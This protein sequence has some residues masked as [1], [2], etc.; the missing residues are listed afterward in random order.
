MYFESQELKVRLC[1]LVKV[2]MYE[3]LCNKKDP[4]LN[5]GYSSM[6]N[7]E[8]GEGAFTCTS[9]MNLTAMCTGHY[10][11]LYNGIWREFYTCGRQTQPLTSRQVLMNIHEGILVQF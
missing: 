2:R 8:G 7:S 6:I 1:D 4:Y 9:N 5:L 3:Y 11:A 10:I